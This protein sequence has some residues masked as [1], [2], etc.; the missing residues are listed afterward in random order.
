MSTGINE[1]SVHWHWNRVATALCT[2]LLTRL[3]PV[4]IALP[5]QNRVVSSYLPH[6]LFL[7]AVNSLS[8]EIFLQIL[9]TGETVTLFFLRCL[10]KYGLRRVKFVLWYIFCTY[11]QLF[12]PFW[13]HNN[14]HKFQTARWTSP[15]LATVCCSNQN[16]GKYRKQLLLCHWYYM[17]YEKMLLY[18]I[19]FIYLSPTSEMTY[20][21]SG[22][23][24]N[25][26][27][28]RCW[29]KN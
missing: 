28:L 16:T 19:Y 8:P 9:L 29:N 21:V 4:S 14:R 12:F 11:N 10:Y 6:L 24:L 25:S 20:I 15:P 18:L 27:H 1:L 13:E 7:S 23:A 2:I 3:L 17:H 22:G 26:T 5:H